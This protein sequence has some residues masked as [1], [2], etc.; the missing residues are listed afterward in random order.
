MTIISE[1]LI[2]A[3]AILKDKIEATFAWTLQELKNSCDIIPIALYSN[4]DPALISV[5]KKNYPET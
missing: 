1:N 2:I 5:M 3:V 4:A